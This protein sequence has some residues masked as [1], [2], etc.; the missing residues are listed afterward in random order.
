MFSD[1]CAKALIDVHGWLFL[2]FFSSPAE[3]DPE[4]ARSG[5]EGDSGTLAP[6]AA[7]A[8]RLRAAGAWSK[9][10][11]APPCG[12]MRAGSCAAVGLACGTGAPTL[13]ARR[14]SDLGASRLLASLQTSAAR[15]GWEAAIGT[16]LARAW[17][18]AWAGVWDGRVTRAAIDGTVRE[19]RC[20]R[21]GSRLLGAGAYSGGLRGLGFSLPLEDM[22]PHIRAWDQWMRA[23]GD[24]YSYKDTD[25]A[26][27]VYEVHRRSIHPAMRVCRE[28]GSLLLNAKT[29]VTC[30]DQG[31]T[32]WL[33]A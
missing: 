17:M 1:E 30:D 23:L 7:E 13:A 33:A 8:D 20:G 32:N 21:P 2:S 24:F 12:S 28:W 6:A 22:E 25:G 19:V 26:G 3:Q 4:R 31:C 9:T 18:A 5:A 14:A 11:R 27:R 10:G 29:Q 16:A 15:A